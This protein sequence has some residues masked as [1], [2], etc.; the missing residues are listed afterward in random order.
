MPAQLNLRKIFIGA[1]LSVIFLSFFIGKIYAAMSLTFNGLPSSVNEDSQF[2]VNVSL[3]AAPINTKYYFRAA[4]FKEGTTRYFG[5]TYNHLG[6]WHN[7]PGEAT[8]FLEI[9][10]NNEG[11]WSGKLKAK[12]DIE[13]SH[14]KGQGDYRFKIGRY[15]KS[16][17]FGSWSGDEAIYINYTPPA[18]P[19]PSP[20]P[21]PSSSP[22]PSP[23]PSPSPT[24]VT[25]TTTTTTKKPVSS[26][27]F[28]SHDSDEMLLGEERKEGEILGVGGPEASEASEVKKEKRPYLLPIILVV[29]GGGLLGGTGVMFYKQSKG[30][31]G[32]KL[33]ESV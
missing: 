27:L 12:V 33:K 13:S 17:Y 3:V 8:R 16:G 31:N 1:I 22:A 25:T 32:D 9:T 29:L 23:S 4:L 10:T 14:F 28:E 20:S 26:S 7:A 11:S 24:P 19:S 5:Y 15:T 18:S 2:E 30:G 21:S 6:E